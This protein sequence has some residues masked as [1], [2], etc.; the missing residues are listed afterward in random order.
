M[1]EWAGPRLE[2]ARSLGATALILLLFLHPIPQGCFFFGDAAVLVLIWVTA[3]SYGCCSVPLSL[4]ATI[5]TLAPASV[6][7]HKFRL[8]I[9]SVPQISCVI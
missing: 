4:F 1:C 9:C 2:S 7:S 6:L 5:G 8:K 3:F